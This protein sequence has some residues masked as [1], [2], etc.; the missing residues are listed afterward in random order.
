MSSDCSVRC[1]RYPAFL[2]A[3]GSPLRFHGCGL[4]ACVHAPLRFVSVAPASAPLSL[5]LQSAVFVAMGP[6][7]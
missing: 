2:L 1:I 5:L 7:R 3:L 4:L 6:I